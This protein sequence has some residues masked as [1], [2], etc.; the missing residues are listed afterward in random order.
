MREIKFRAWDE[1]QKHM[2][3]QGVADMENIQ[4]FMFHYGDKILMQYTGFKDFN[5]K[6]IYEGDILRYTHYMARLK[7][8]T[9]IVRFNI[10]CGGWFIASQ[11]S[12][13]ADVLVEQHNEEWQMMQNY[14]PSPEHKVVV[15][16]NIYE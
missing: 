7:P 10:N 16:G 14:T 4:S 12:T 3:Y 15:V 5:G 11:A 6:E 8:R 13:L 1:K 9:E 2:A